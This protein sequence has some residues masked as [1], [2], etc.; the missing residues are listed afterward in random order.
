MVESLEPR[1]ATAGDLEAI[2]ALLVAAGLPT[3]GVA[4][5]IEHFRVFD[6][7][8]G[9]V[10][11]AGVELHGECALLR[12]LVVAPELRGRGLAGRLVEGVI[13]HARAL[14]SSAVYLLTTD[15]DG[16]FAGCG[17]ERIAR[18]DAPGEIRDCQEFRELCPDSAILMQRD[19]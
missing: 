18:Q 4:E 17:F 9:V 5:S 14:G 15:A 11:S 19:I 3:D 6:I 2:H 13:E 12:S 1:A 7:G 16:Y 8:D 10:A